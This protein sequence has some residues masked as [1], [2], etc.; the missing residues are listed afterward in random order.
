[1][2]LAPY[3]NEDM[4]GTIP[5]RDTIIGM[6]RPEAREGGREQSNYEAMWCRKGRPP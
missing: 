4:D 1:M 3:W 2:M 5:A 6:G